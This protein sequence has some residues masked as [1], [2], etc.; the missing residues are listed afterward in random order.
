MILVGVSSVL[1]LAVAMNVLQIDI[2][3][4]LET[5][6]EMIAMAP[7]SL[8]NP[9]AAAALQTRHV[10]LP[11]DTNLAPPISPQPTSITYNRLVEVGKGDTLAKLL[12]RS[13]IDRRTAHNAVVALSKHYDPRRIRRGQD[14]ELTFETTQTFEHGDKIKD[15]TFVGLMIEP[16]YKTEVHVFRNETGGFQS[17][18]R[19]K[20]LRR[21]AARAESTIKNSL[22]VA[23]RDVDVPAVVIA[24]MI[25]LLSWDVDFQR[26]IRTGDT[27]KVMY[28]QVY[29]DSGALVYNGNVQ[30]VSMILSGKKITVYRYKMPDGTIDYFDASGKASRKALMRTPIDGARLSSTFGMRKHP[31]LGYS[32]MHRGVD[33]AA[34]T[35]T[36][37]YAAGNGTVAYAGRK[38]SFGNY[39]RLRHNGTYETAY[40]HLNG[41]ARGVRTGKRVEQGQ[42][43][44]YVGT[45]GRSTGPHLHYEVHRGGR[46]VNPLRIDMPSGR[47][48]K[49]DELK[50]F[51]AF[52]QDVDRTFANLGPTEVASTA[53]D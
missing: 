16:D 2:D 38:G 29:D 3:G 5:E 53:L 21:T 19:E 7:I 12:D 34:P 6:D 20:T 18:E 36:P 23:G 8:G 15:D 42:I 48:L 37:I 52:R 39:I 33:F 35:G 43:I 27:F 26:D 9:A 14:I 28:E 40:A 13:G 10:S 11:S 24:R 50:Q 1:A 32:K 45:T 49:G 47:T 51:L 41:F 46:Q 22:Y 25:R 44:G 4:A 31:I 30:F 17:E